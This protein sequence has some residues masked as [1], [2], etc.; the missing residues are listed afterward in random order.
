[1]ANFGTRVNLII[2]R[3]NGTPNILMDDDMVFVR[4]GD[5]PGFG[6]S[7]W[8]T[9]VT[10]IPSASFTLPFGWT[11]QALPNSPLAGSGPDQIWDEVIHNVSYIALAPDSPWGGLAWFGNQTFTFDNFIL[12]NTQPSI[13]T[14]FCSP[15]NINSTGVSAVPSGTMT[16]PA[17]SGL[18]LDA[19]RGPANEFGYFLVGTGST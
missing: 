4:T 14:P 19:R 16:N 2:G 5:M 6:T 9:F 10:P 15:M 13:G 12:D 3:D 7:P 17:G 11:A 1:M 8:E 18:H